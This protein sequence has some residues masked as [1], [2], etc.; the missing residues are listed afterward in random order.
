[1]YR[2][3]W[4]L[5]ALSEE[6]MGW[7]QNGLFSFGFPVNQ[8]KRCPQ[9]QTHPNMLVVGKHFTFVLLIVVQWEISLNC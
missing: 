5:S 3:H 4:Y 7:F 2:C 1:M 9:K 6:Q 8:P